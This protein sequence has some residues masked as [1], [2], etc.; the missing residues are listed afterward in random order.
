MFYTFEEDGIL[1]TVNNQRVDYEAVYLSGGKVFYIF[2]AGSGLLELS[3]KKK[4][5][6]GKWHKVVTTRNTFNG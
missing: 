6:D 1:L 3:S 5:N 4:V 2:N